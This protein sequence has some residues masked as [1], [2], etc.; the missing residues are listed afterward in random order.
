MKS[1]IKIVAVVSASLLAVSCSMNSDMTLESAVYSSGPYVKCYYD[2]ELSVSVLDDA[3]IGLPILNVGVNPAEVENI[4]VLDAGGPEK[5]WYMELCAKHGDVSF[6]GMDYFYDSPEKRCFAH[7]LLSIDLVCDS[8]Y[9]AAHTAGVSLMDV[10]NYSASSLLRWIRNG[11]QMASFERDCYITDKKGDSL[12]PEDMAML[13][14][15]NIFQLQFVSPPDVPGLRNFKLTVRY[16]DG[17]V[18]TMDVQLKF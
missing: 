9:D 16:D 5:D 14:Y 8:D 12:V 17:G 11:Y 3:S 18:S 13:C 7:D 1:F 2:G 10:V 4:T 15:F 6:K